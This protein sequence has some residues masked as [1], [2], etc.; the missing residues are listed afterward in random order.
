[1]GVQGP[2]SPN[3]VVCLGLDVAAS[4]GFAAGLVFIGV[5]EFAAGLD[6][7]FAAR[8]ENALGEVGYYC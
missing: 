7:E 4:L 8:V 3:C 1:M 6:L 2:C 5:L